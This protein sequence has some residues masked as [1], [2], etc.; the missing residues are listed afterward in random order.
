[1]KG[2][3]KQQDPTSQGPDSSWLAP[4][5]HAFQ[6]LFLRKYFAPFLVQHLISFV[7]MHFHRSQGSPLRMSLQINSSQW[8]P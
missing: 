2:G 1:M 5:S 3:A 8:T 7:Y 6:F 4:R